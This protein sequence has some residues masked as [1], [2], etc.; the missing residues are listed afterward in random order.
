MEPKTCEIP[1]AFRETAPPGKTSDMRC[2]L[3]PKGGLLFYRILHSI[4]WI[5]PPG[6]WERHVSLSIG[7]ADWGQPRM[8]PTQQERQAFQEWCD[9][10]WPDAVRTTYMFGGQPRIVHLYFLT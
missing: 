10:E 7:F 1:V 3:A 5:D 8:S 6:R 9:K 4:D 2:W